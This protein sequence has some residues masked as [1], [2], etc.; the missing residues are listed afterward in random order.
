MSEKCKSASSSASHI[1]VKEGFGVVVWQ[2]KSDKIN[3]LKNA[4]APA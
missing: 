2:K 4:N 3:W 1:A